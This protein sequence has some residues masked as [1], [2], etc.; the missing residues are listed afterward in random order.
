MTGLNGPCGVGQVEVREVPNERFETALARSIDEGQPV[1]G[2]ECGVIVRRSECYPCQLEPR[3]DAH[4]ELAQFTGEAEAG[5]L[6]SWKQSFTAARGSAWMAQREPMDVQNLAVAAA[7]AFEYGL[8][9]K[10]FNIVGG[11]KDA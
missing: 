1:S 2:R 8:D 7:L 6:L 4:E 9:E 3:G 11:A 5:N 10:V